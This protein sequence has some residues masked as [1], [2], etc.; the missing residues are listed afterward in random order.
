MIVKQVDDRTYSVE[1]TGVVAVVASADAASWA[2]L[3]ANAER[4]LDA[5]QGLLEE[6]EFIITELDLCEP[7]VFE[8]V[9]V[10][11]EAIAAA[12]GEA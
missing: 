7:E 10:A 3:F 12:E 1:G 9:R 4:T 8:S 11:R 2:R 5:C 6:I